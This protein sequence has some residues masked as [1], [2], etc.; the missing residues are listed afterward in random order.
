[1]P[2]KSSKSPRRIG[3]PPAGARAGERVKDYPQLSIRL[4]GDIKAKLQALSL[5]SARPQWRIITDAIECYLRERSEAEQRIVAELV[6]RSR[7]REPRHVV[8]NRAG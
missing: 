7:S 6:G 2:A 5:V 1:M 3:R 8:K 4:P